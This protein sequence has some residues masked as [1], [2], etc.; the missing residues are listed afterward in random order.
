MNIIRESLIGYI[1]EEN[2]YINEPMSK[3]TS[4]KIG[5]EADI[6]VTPESVEEIKNIIEIC[7]KNETA[8]Q[9]IG[10]GSNLLVCDDGIEGVVIKISNKFSKITINGETIKAQSGVILSTLSKFIMDAHLTGFEFAS[11]IPGTL[12]G[13]VYMNAGAYGGEMK[14]VLV[15]VQVLDDTG[16][17]IYLKNGELDLGYRNS[18]FHSGKYI[19]L[20][21]DIKLSKGNH[22][23]IRV[24]T[25]EL[26]KKRTSKQPLHLPSAGSTFK[27]PLDNYAGKLIQDAG[28]KGVRFGDAQVSDKHCGFVVN[29]GSASCK[30]ILTLIQFIQ[31]VVLDKFEIEMEPEV[32]FL[33]RGFNV[34]GCS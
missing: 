26:T 32:R 1:K 20:E 6:L 2:I 11:G 19:V 28:L 23:D 14:D 29:L 9:V 17:I 8:Y 4:F 16:N 3:H 18:I 34:K 31:K 12:G 33:G 24:Y 21:A 27:R 22:E 15:G 5:G 10:N 7:K 25:N 30:D 13:A